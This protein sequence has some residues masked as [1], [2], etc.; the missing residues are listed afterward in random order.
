MH[1]IVAWFQHS[2]DAIAPWIQHYGYAA[3][4]VC[5][6]LEALGAPLPGESALIGSSLLAARGDLS[7]VA[8]LSCVWIA[9]VAGDSIGYG[10]GR[11]G[12]HALPIRFGPR[13][14]LTSDRIARTEDLFRRRGF[15]IVFTARFVVVLRQLNGVI[16]GS[17]RMP[18]PHFLVA[19]A[20]GG[21][22]WTLTWGLGP[23]L[24]VR[25]FK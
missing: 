3:I 1:S 24:L 10:I 13:L 2:L 11:L 18:W 25:V 20:A 14:G 6:G 7:I 16:A 4:F 5:V 21:L 15:A 12:G 23:Y 17:V 19:N 8:A 9:A 22:L